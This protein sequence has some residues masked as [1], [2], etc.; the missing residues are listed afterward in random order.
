MLPT[1]HPNDIQCFETPYYAFFAAI[2]VPQGFKPH[3]LSIP[4]TTKIVQ[5]SIW[6]IF[7]NSQE[8]RDPTWDLR[9]EGRT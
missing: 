9:R 1:R 2:P 3:K 5:K 8:T 7:S 4:G 6:V